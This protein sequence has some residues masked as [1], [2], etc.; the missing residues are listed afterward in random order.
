MNKGPFKAGYRVD[1]VDSTGKVLSQSP[2]YY[3]PPWDDMDQ[4]SKEAEELV[5]E[6][7]KTGVCAEVRISVMCRR[8]H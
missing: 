5:E 3:D 4:A 8:V 7:A 1:V 2:I 6:V